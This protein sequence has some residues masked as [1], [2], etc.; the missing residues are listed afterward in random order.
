MRHCVSRGTIEGVMVYRNLKEHFTWSGRREVDN[1]D[2]R[3]DVVHYTC[4]ALCNK[5]SPTFAGLLVSYI[6]IYIYIYA[7]CKKSSLLGA[8]GEVHNEDARADV[9]H[10]ICRFFF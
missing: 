8:G 5:K 4:R 7:Y 1:E 10:D 3:S 6:C 2:A 9:V